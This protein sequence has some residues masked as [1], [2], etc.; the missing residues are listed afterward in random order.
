MLCRRARRMGLSLEA[1]YRYHETQQ[2]IAGCARSVLRAVPKD[3]VGVFIRPFG[4][5]RKLKGYDEMFNVIIMLV[6]AIVFSVTMS[7]PW[8]VIKDAANVTESRQ[9]VPFLIYVALIW[10]LAL[11]V[12]PGIFVLVARAAR[13][14][15]GSQG[16][17]PD[18]YFAAGLHTD[19]HRYI[20][21]DCIQFADADGELWL[22][23]QCI[24]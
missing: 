1:I 13:R 4:S 5:D 23:P 15:S 20:C 11:G 9:I 8:G 2:L 6:V 17:Q 18:R 12:F 3:N 22:Y 21:L 7:G 10:I 19:S 16:Q 24:V 14:V